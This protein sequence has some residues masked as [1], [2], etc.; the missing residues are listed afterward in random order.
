[1]LKAVREAKVTSSWLNPNS[2]YE[3]AL[4]QFVRALLDPEHGKLFLNDFAILQRRVAQLGVFNA[5]SQLVLKLTVPGMPDI[6]QGTELWDLSLVD[7]DN[8]RPVNYAQCRQLLEGLHDANPQ[9]LLREPA[10]GRIKLWVTSRLLQLRV[11]RE[12][13]LRD[14]DYLALTVTGA[15]AEH[16]CAFARRLG[17]TMIIVVVPRLFAR[18]LPDITATMIETET[19]GDT[20]VQL[21]NGAPTR[22]RNRLTGK[23]CDSLTVDAILGDFPWA[24]LEPE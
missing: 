1:M 9:N 23:R 20:L 2:A 7:P 10:D 22:W 14:G 3:G 12:A 4:T 21:P 8:R 19:W 17:E 16:L 13:L 15:R 5:L 11:E 18:L 6:Y 24:V